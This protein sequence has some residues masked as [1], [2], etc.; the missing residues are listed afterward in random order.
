MN[1]VRVSR[2]FPRLKSRETR[3]RNINSYLPDRSCKGGEALEDLVKY[4]ADDLITRL[5]ELEKEADFEFLMSL[6]DDD[7]IIEF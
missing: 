6:S 1:V 5:E 2:V 4:L 7:I 3:V